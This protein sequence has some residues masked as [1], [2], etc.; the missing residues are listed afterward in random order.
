MSLTPK[1]GASPALARQWR[2]SGH[3]P[4][5]GGCWVPPA[6]VFPTWPGASGSEGS[7]PPNLLPQVHVPASRPFFHLAGVFVALLPANPRN[8]RFVQIVQRVPDRR[9]IHVQRPSS[10]SRQCLPTPPIL[11]HEPHFRKKQDDPSIRW[12]LAPT[13]GRLLSSFILKPRS[14]VLCPV[15]YDLRPTDICDTIV[16]QSVIPILLVVSR[17]C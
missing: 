7:D 17:S 9:G 2:A 4:P 6:S 8:E 5:I 3:A 15:V 1:A 13:Q 11:D 14:F 10:L 12:S 16:H